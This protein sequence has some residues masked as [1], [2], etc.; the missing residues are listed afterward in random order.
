M[1]KFTRRTHQEKLSPSLCLGRHST[2]SRVSN[3][4]NSITT[5]LF[6]NRFE[7]DS[8]ENLGLTGY[9][10]VSSKQS[11]VEKYIEFKQLMLKIDPAE[12]DEEERLASAMRTYQVTESPVPTDGPISMPVFGAA[13]MMPGVTS[14]AAPTTPMKTPRS[15]SSKTPRSPRG[16]KSSSSSSSSSKKKSQ[17]KRK[18]KIES[19]ESSDD[20]DCDPDFRA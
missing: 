5:D 11:L 12:E 9:V 18:R 20:S 4:L 16:E 2:L 10:E 1:P 3:F 17:K 19:D 14:M 8:I 15:K 13:P 7:Y 6:S